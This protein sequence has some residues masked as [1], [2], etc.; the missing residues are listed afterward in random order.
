MRRPLAKMLVTS[1]GHIVGHNVGHMGFLTPNNPLILKKKAPAR[2]RGSSLGRKRPRK[3]ET[4]SCRISV[5]CSAKISVHLL[6]MQGEKT[7]KNSV[8]R[9]NGRIPCLFCALACYAESSDSSGGWVA[10]IMHRS[11]GIE[12]RTPMGRLFA[13][14]V[15]MIITLALQ[16]T[17]KAA[18]PVTLPVDV[19]CAAEAAKAERQ[20]SI[21]SQ[22]LD[23]ISL[24]ESGRYDKE[25]R[26][27][28]AWPWTVTA[29]GEGKYFPTKQDAIAEVHRLRGKGV[30]NIDVGCMQIN[31]KHHPKAFESLEQAFDPAANVSYAARFLVGLYQSTENWVMAASY[32]HSQTPHLAAAYRER[33]AKVMNN[34]GSRDAI[35]RI[36]PFKGQQV[37]VSTPPQAL[38]PAAVSR[39][40]APPKAAA[41][42]Q[43]VK[44]IRSEWQ[45]RHAT[46]QEE[47][48]RIAEAYRQARLVEYQ[49]RRADRKP[50]GLL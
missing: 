30:Q 13:I 40:T 29:N 8:C 48:R 26:A 37:A 12:A 46:E 14:L 34:G 42:S 36:N 20:Y 17:A 23:A 15:S 39:Q 9:E 38:P 27:T 43:R 18:I 2:S 31:L 41:S 22:L 10:R 7:G 32:Y 5:C 16:N 47:S 21:P 24:V 50:G 49:M 1:S 25:N 28:L 33:L 6:T 11:W 19:V 3:A 44:D 35:A 45:N 4:G